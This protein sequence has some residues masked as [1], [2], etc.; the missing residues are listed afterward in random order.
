MTGLYAV[1]SK[2]PPDPIFLGCHLE[3]YAATLKFFGPS[4]FKNRERTFPSSWFLLIFPF[5]VPISLPYDKKYFALDRLP[6]SSHHGYFSSCSSPKPNFPSSLFTP[7]EYTCFM[8]EASRMGFVCILITS[9]CTRSPIAEIP[10]F[11][12]VP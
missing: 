12:Q 2:F 11:Q 6:P 9:F 10:L 4:Q 7:V 1:K 5:P 8:R 3:A